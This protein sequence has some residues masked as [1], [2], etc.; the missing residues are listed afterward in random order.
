MV[1]EAFSL[2]SLV[3]ANL[4]SLLQITCLTDGFFSFCKSPLRLSYT[5]ICL[6]CH[7]LMKAVASD[8]EWMV[9]VFV[10]PGLMVAAVFLRL[11]YTRHSSPEAADDAASAFRSSIFVIVFLV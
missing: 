10:L 1:R 8:G 4:K 6:C 5:F 3:A 11:I 7:P 2:L 9:R